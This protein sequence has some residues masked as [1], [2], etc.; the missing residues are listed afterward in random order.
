MKT[1][2]NRL[3]FATGLF[4]IAA[5]LID[6]VRILINGATPHD[7]VMLVAFAIFVSGFICVLVP[8]AVFYALVM[9]AVRH[10]TTRSETHRQ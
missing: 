8:C 4:L 1:L 5:G 9:L 7:S 6:I 10:G 2:F 3:A